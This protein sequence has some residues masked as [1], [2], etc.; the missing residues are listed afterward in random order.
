MMEHCIAV[1]CGALWCLKYLLIQKS[2]GPVGPYLPITIS[3]KTHF[4]RID[5]SIVE[6]D[7]C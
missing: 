4:W 1:H 2:F 6:D 5:L 3:F 7:S